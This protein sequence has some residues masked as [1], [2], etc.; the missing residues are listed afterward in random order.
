MPKRSNYRMVDED[1]PQFVRFWNAYPKRVAK[2]E[3]RQAW[4]VL[5]PS[6]ETVD[7][8]LRT[9]DWQCRQP[10]W[11][12]DGGQFIPYPASWLRAERWDD[13]PVG[14]PMLDER[15]A[16]TWAAAA[17]F[18]KGGGGHGTH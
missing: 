10:N 6:P 4:A 18:I 16:H 17:E 15:T 7:R 5:S 13:E 2:K 3:A 11:I 12:R 14:V 9:L 1:D 8:M